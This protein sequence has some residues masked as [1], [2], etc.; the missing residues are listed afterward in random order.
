MCTAINE[1]RGRH[2]FGRT[3]DLECSFGEEIVV[4]PRKFPLRFLHSRTLQ[5]HYAII[6]TAHIEGGVPLYYDAANEAGLC[7]AALNFPHLSRY[8]PPSADKRCL[9]SFEVIPKLLA[10]AKSVE[11]VHRILSNARITDDSFSR[12]LPPSPLH[13]IFADKSSSITVEQSELGLKI[14]EN[15]YGVLSNS[16]DFPSQMHNLERYLGIIENELHITGLHSRGLDAF[17]I[18]G[19]YSSGSRFVRAA[20][21]KSRTLP[22]RERGAA[23]SR[24][25]H[26]LD[27][28]SQ[29]SGITRADDGKAVR[30]VYASAIDTQALE[31]Y[32]TTYENRRIKC[33]KL[34]TPRAIGE[35]LARFPMHSEEDILRL[36]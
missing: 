22:E 1:T 8:F 16:P 18:P 20:F 26:L 31:Y 25:L 21:A 14:H 23:I 24:F 17:G 2:I 15:P 13:W 35:D 27:T 32:F 10:T 9:A 11:E 28:V 19:D 29:P 12:E 5:E 30:T 3:L 34:D 33:L 36:N 7:A 6:G 4:A